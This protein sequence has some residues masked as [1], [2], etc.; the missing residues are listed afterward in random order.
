MFYH[1]QLNRQ[2]IYFL[3]YQA[4]ERSLKFDAMLKRHA[5]V[6]VMSFYA[7]TKQSIAGVK[8]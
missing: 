5:D 4:A 8:P 1:Y 7:K 3:I 6:C 2:L